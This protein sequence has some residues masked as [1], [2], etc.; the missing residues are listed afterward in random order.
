MRGLATAAAVGAIAVSASA[1]ARAENE[2]VEAFARVVVDEVE[3]RT[4]PGVNFRVIGTLKR[5]E[6]IAVDGRPTSG[7]WLRV[8]TED[9]RI[10]YVLGEA[11]QVF[12]V[13][14]DEPDAPSRPGFFAPPPLRG[15]HGGLAL[16]GG[17]FVGPLADGSRRAFGYM[18]A[19]PQLVLHETLSLEG[20]VGDA[21]TV[22]GA[23]LVY[24]AGASVYLFPRWVVCPFVGIGGGGFSS[25]PKPDAFVLPREDLMLARAGGGLLFAIR[26]RILV[27]LE[28]TNLT[29]FDSDQYKNAQTY[30]GGLGVYF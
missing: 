22:D 1:P 7:F 13:D 14:P 29:L 12:A 8:I 2:N 6:T 25:L 4:G 30:V 21:L 18:E 17:V 23:Q 20:F 19:R 16:L 26:G 11:V 28:A 3:L 24:G 10:V 27:R 5:G 15:A 9:G